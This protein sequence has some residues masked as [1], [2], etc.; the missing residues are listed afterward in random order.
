MVLAIEGSRTPC[1]PAARVGARWRLPRRSFNS[2]ELRS[3]STAEQL[4]PMGKQ[5]MSPFSRA[6]NAPLLRESRRDEPMAAKQDVTLTRFSSAA[7]EE[8]AL[9][10][11]HQ[12]RAAEDPCPR[13]QGN[14]RGDTVDITFEHTEHT[15]L[16]EHMERST[17]P[18]R[19]PSAICAVV[20]R[21]Y[22]RSPSPLPSA[23]AK[24]P[25]RQPPALGK[26]LLLSLC[27][28]IGWMFGNGADVDLTAVSTCQQL[29][30]RGIHEA[31]R[32]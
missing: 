3:K 8:V 21:A 29:E 6:L 12:R 15:S 25:G 2:G 10:A 23:D 5:E 22:T 19:S 9:V 30:R 7:M 20:P 32:P 11:Q 24:G 13:R 28:V 1:R 27:L 26:D 31:S 16:N 4:L 18:P 17:P 14:F